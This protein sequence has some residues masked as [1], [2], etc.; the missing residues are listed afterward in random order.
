MLPWTGGPGKSWPR[1]LK[2]AH[3]RR[4][5]TQ[6]SGPNPY[7]VLDTA[8]VSKVLLLQHLSM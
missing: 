6:P 3:D 7:P 4:N 5:I 1:G 8:A 2:L